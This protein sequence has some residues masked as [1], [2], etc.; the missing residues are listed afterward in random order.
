MIKVR[1]IKVKSLLSS[2]KLGAD[3]AINPYAGCPHGCLYCY[4]A[5]MRSAA[6]R[7]EPWGSYIDVKCPA[8]PLPLDRIF[9]K[10]VLLSSM[11]D[12]Y[13]PYEER[14][15]V[16]RALLRS[17]IPA[18]PE[19]TVITKSALASRDADI[20]KEFP[21]ARVV[22]SFSSLDDGFR[23]EAEPH[24]SSPAKKLAAMETL[25]KAGVDVAVMTAPIFPKIT[26]C[27]RII[28]ACAPFV[29]YMTFDS[30]NLRAGN[31]AGILAFV[32]AL[33]PDLA[34]LYRNIYLE[35]DRGFWRET[36]KSV[37]EICRE[38]NIPCSI[39]F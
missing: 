26:D 22:F 28:E 3:F 7:G 10:S 32:R 9:R 17:M 35:G 34:P 39:F 36:K 27:A 23:R 18:R 24:A 5:C 13:N 8:S 19:I 33:R 25:K 21:R 30:L 2:T 4:A 38:R 6:A 12:P 20:L 1:Y 37:E 11:T 15:C 29:S 16:T 14:A 31:R